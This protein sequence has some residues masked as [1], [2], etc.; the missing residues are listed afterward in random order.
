MEKIKEFL[1]KL[2]LEKPEDRYHFYLADENSLPQDDAQKEAVQTPEAT[3]ADVKNIFPSID[4]NLEYVRVKYNAMI[5]SDIIIREFNLIARNRQYKAF[6]LFIDGMV[7]TD[8]INNYVLKPLMMK[9]QANTFDGD[10]TRIVSEAVTNN[11]TVRKVKK[12]D[13]VEYISS[14][15]FP[16][17]SVK[18]ES[19]FSDIFDGVNSGNCALFIDTLN[20]AFNIDVKGFKQRSI[21][22]PNNEIVI[23]GPQEAFVE[24]IRTNTSLIRRIVNSENLV[25]ESVSVGKISQTNCAV[26]YLSN[27]ANN[28][29]V[30]EVKYR[31]NNLGV[32]SLL[33]SGQLEQLIEETNRYSIPQILSTERPDKVTKYLFEGRVAVLV[34]RKSLLFSYACHFN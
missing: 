32:D 1:K 19:E 10:Q 21:D 11:I 4:V 25:V 2:F 33:S 8:L 29:L 26:C 5:N 20:I 9:N 22:S 23:K 14:C 17:N 31:M 30:A 13:I 24:N 6:L 15:L 12:F 16:Q 18:K 7:D 28:D 27:V 34:N 3:K